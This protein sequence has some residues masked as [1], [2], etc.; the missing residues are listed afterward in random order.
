MRAQD[1]A[2]ASLIQSPPAQAVG[3]GITVVASAIWG[4]LTGTLFFVMVALFLCDVAL[5]SLKAINTGGLTGWCPERFQRGLT[6]FLAALVGVILSVL[7]DLLLQDMG[8]VGEGAL[9]TSGVL[10]FV[11]FGF[12]VSAGRNLAH[13]FPWVEVWLDSVLRKVRNPEEPPKRRAEDRG[14]A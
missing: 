7:A 10:G 4:G 8:L 3:A 2:V 13:F 6:K 11:C 12:M 9:L 5:G 1:S 14:E